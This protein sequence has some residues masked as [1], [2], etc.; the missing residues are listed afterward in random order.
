MHGAENH[1]AGRVY[2][3]ETMQQLGLPI[4]SSFSEAAGVIEKGDLVYMTLA[5]VSPKLAEMIALRNILGLRS[6]VHT[7]ARKLNPFSAPCMLQS[8]FHPGF[9]DIHQKAGLL[10]NQP[11]MAVFR[12]EGGEVERRPNKPTEVRTLHNGELAEEQWPTIIPEPRQTPEEDMNINR[13]PALW[14]G[15]STDEYGEAAV[16][17]TVAVALKACGKADGIEDAQVMA[18]AMWRDRDKSRFA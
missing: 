18:E 10:L 1:T 3:L 17:G 14:K 9:L 7:L 13:L 4:A 5:D 16:T 15:E 11:H 6:P 2:T 8:V 12:G